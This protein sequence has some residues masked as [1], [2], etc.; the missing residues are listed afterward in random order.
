MDSKCI[1]LISG[2]S[3][4]VDGVASRLKA[5]PGKVQ[6]T[7]FS[8]VQD[9]LHDQLLALEPDVIILDA[10]D[11]GVRE[12]CPLY[13]LVQLLPEVKFLV[14]DSERSHL[15]VVTNRREPIADAQELLEQVLATI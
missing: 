13:D 14:L 11:P 5:Q 6:P 3:L 8:P 4:L 15:Q 10:R 2:Q 7:V 12:N 1:A 9:D